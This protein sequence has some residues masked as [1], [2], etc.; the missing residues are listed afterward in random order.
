[1]ND[2]ELDEIL[3]QWKSPEPGAE[4]RARIRGLQPRGRRFAWPTWHISKGLFAGVAAGA[5]MCLFGISVAFPQAFAPAAIRFNLL[6]EFVSWHDDGSSQV[7]EVRAST[8]IGGREIF[9]ERHVPDDELMTLHMH[10]FDTIHRMLGVGE[11]APESFG[12][13]CSVPNARADGHETLLGYQATKLVYNPADFNGG[14]Y[15]EWRAPELEC[16]VMKSTWEKLVNGEL[17]LRDERRSLTV[18]VNHAK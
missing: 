14:R 8:M 2:T 6:S 4:L 11:G 15:I 13:D 16:I 10:F 18:R 12:N 1:M 17:R 3:N 9:L 5:V 7:R